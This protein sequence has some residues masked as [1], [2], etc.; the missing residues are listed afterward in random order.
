MS[1][2]SNRPPARYAS[3]ASAGRTS[4]RACCH[5]LETHISTKWA[6]PI[7]CS[8]LRTPRSD[9]RSGRSTQ[10]PIRK[11]RTTTSTRSRPSC[12]PPRRRRGTERPTAPTRWPAPRC[13]VRSGAPSATLR[14]SRRWRLARPSTAGLSWCPA[15]SATRSF[16]RT[17]TFCSM[18]SG[19]ATASSRTAVRRRRTSCGRCRCGERGRGHG[20]CTTAS[21]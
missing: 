4:T 6:S 16:I 9:A 15:R 8:L 7:G 5:S 14:R 17:A 1:R 18:T 12:E 13:S 20:T 11:T 21:R 10:W 19:R 2:L 3:A